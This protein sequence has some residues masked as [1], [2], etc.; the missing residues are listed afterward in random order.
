MLGATL[1]HHFDLQSQDLQGTVTA[2]NENTYV[3][4]LMKTAEDIEQLTRF[5]QEAITIMESAKFPVHKWVRHRNKS[6]QNT[7]LR[8]G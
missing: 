7:R 1:Q 8:V 2:L 5:K 4:N 6:I 3:D